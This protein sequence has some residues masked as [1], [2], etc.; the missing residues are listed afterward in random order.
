MG[1]HFLNILYLLTR[2][3]HKILLNSKIYLSLYL[4]VIPTEEFK[5]MNKP[6]GNGV[7]DCHDSSI[8]SLVFQSPIEAFEGIALE[9]IR[10]ETGLGV[11]SPRRLLME[12]SLVSLYSYFLHNKTK[13]ARIPDSLIKYSMTVRR[14][15]YY[16]VG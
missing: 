10:N 14:P 9:D 1:P 2:K 6:S 16:L 7:L 11:K 15:G 3:G 13:A 4:A 12:A 8:G 5:I